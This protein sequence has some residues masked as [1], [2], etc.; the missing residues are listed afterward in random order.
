MK[1]IISLVLLIL[2][3]IFF[4]GCVMEDDDNESV[5]TGNASIK[6]TV[7]SN[8]IWGTE[9]EEDPGT[10]KNY[11]YLYEDLGSKS[12]SYPKKYS[13]SSETNSGI[14]T[15]E[16]I[17]PG[18]YYLVVFYDY[19]G[20]SKEDNVLNRGDYYSIYSST[21][22]ENP[23]VEDASK[24]SISENI[25]Q[26]LEINITSGNVLGKSGSGNGRVFMTK[27]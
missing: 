15:I 16:N 2:N 17:V 21:S 4:S 5:A 1:K 8:D 13:N 26:E 10:K 19:S 27:E 23:Y 24:V 12:S 11:V 7:N 3:L 18:D 25:I 22:N 9:D 6:V 20:G 14:I